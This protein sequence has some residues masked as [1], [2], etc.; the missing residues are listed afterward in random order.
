MY[1]VVLV[2]SAVRPEDMDEQIT[3]KQTRECRFKAN[4]LLGSTW[5]WAALILSCICK[6]TYSTFAEGCMILCVR[7]SASSGSTSL[8]NKAC[9][10]RGPMAGWCL[11]P[12]ITS[13]STGS[14]FTTNCT[15]S[16]TKLVLASK[17]Q[18]VRQREQLLEKTEIDFEARTISQ[19]FLSEL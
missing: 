18:Q 4:Q 10:P 9:L 5:G 11:R 12:H 19:D 15:F 16:Y 3:R 14:D 1:F 17:C 8:T 6:I 2:R 7:S 13:T